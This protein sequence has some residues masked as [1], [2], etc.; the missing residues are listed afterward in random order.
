[1]KD[2][3]SLEFDMFEDVRRNLTRVFE[4]QGHETLEAERAALYVVQA[5]RE[6]PKLIA[7]VTNQHRPDA[8]VLSILN[9]VFDNLPALARARAVLAGNDDPAVH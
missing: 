3:S 2:D 8:E 7:A 9:K 1:M 4:G 6:V 5:L